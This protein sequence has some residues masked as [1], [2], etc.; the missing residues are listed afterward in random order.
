MALFDLS[1]EQIMFRYIKRAGLVSGI[2]LIPITVKYVQKFIEFFNN[3]NPSLFQV[4]L[5]IAIG[6]FIIH[7]VIKSLNRLIFF[8]ILLIIISVIT[9]IITIV[10]SGSFKIENSHITNNVTINNI[11]VIDSVLILLLLISFLLDILTR[12]PTKGSPI[13]KPPSRRHHEKPVLQHHEKVEKLR[14]REGRR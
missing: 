7:A 14:G 10:T 6:F 12:K 11:L 8:V 1:W 3:I 13:P 9:A 5:V 4:S 2:I